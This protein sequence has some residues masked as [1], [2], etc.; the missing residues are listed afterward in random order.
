MG[1]RM[2][3]MQKYHNLDHTQLYFYIRSLFHIV[4]LISFQPF[5]VKIVTLTLQIKS[6]TKK[7]IYDIL[8]IILLLHVHRI[9]DSVTNSK[10]VKT[11]FPLSYPHVKTA[12]GNLPDE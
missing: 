7:S 5:T 6:F 8:K 12:E 11:I 3:S 4:L 10:N 9:T 1:T 2:F